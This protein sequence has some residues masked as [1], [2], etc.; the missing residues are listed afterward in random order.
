MATKKP[1]T[2]KQ[3]SRT[4]ADGRKGRL[5]RRIASGVMRVLLVAAIIGAATLGLRHLR[6]YVLAQP[7][8]ARNVARIELADRPEWMSDWLARQ[9]RLELAGGQEA[10]KTLDPQLA[11]RVHEAAQGCPWIRALHE[12]R[13]ERRPEGPD[14][15][16][17]GAGRVIVRAEW[18]RPAAVGVWGEREEYVDAEGVVLPAHQVRRWLGL[19]RVI[20]QLARPPRPGLTWPGEDMA[21][22][23]SMLRLLRDKPYYTEITAIDVA[24]FGR[25]QSLTAPAIR[26]VAAAGQAVTD[27]RFGDLP[28]DGMPSVGGPSVKRKLAYLDGWYRRNQYQL[29]GPEYLDLRYHQLRSSEVYAPAF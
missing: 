22:G 25:R 24:N 26:L 10:H 8:F 18:R 1:T 28:S 7:T 16:T 6:R 23:L 5:N 19:P 29:A 4:A 12:V 9:I 20:G 17:C 27:I 14:D 13:V 11:R 2:R 15:T 21:A 3:K